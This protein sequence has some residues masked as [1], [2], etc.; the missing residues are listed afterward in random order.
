MGLLKD[1]HGWQFLTIEAAE[2]LCMICVSPEKRSIWVIDLPK[3][4]KGFDHQLCVFMDL[5]KTVN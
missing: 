2:T 4:L 3:N 5:L 1:V